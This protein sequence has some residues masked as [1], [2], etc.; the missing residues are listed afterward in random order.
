[1][2]H[3][4]FFC[5]DCKNLFSKILALTDYEEGEVLCPNCGSK[6]LEQRCSPFTCDYL[7]EERVNRAS[8][9]QPFADHGRIHNP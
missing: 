8:R 6:M 1:M 2:P 7:E 9:A 4:E 3:F 5:N